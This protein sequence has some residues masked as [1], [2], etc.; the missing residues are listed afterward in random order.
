MRLRRGIY[1]HS[2]GVVSGELGAD[3]RRSCSH[4][5]TSPHRRPDLGLRGST[6][7]GNIGRLYRY[8][9]CGHLPDSQA[10]A[11]PLLGKP[12]Q[13]TIQR[14]PEKPPILPGSGP[15]VSRDTS[16]DASHLGTSSGDPSSVGAS[17]SRALLRDVPAGR[18]LNPNR[19]ETRG[20]RTGPRH[21]LVHP[22]ATHTANQRGELLGAPPWR[23]QSCNRNPLLVMSATALHRV[24]S[25]WPRSPVTARRWADR[26]SVTDP[27][28]PWGCT[29]RSRV[30]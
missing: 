9:A 13:G 17:P 19:G 2:R 3:R 11:P 23:D 1:R 28:Q 22:K 30:R 29:C 6:G 12:D 24:S 10:G 27:R 20:I 8:E 5:R 21:Q 4:D 7:L 25:L 16:R 18:V 15:S 14:F 26:S